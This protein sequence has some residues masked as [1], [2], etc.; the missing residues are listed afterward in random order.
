[1]SEVYWACYE[2]GGDGLA[3]LEGEERVSKP[4]EVR[5]P[6]QWPT[7]TAVGRGFIAYPDALRAAVPNVVAA[8][9]QIA[10]TLAA[11][12]SAAGAAS[13]VA[14]GAVPAAAPA[15]A[16]ADAAAVAPPADPTSI[17]LL[18]LLPHATQIAR[19]ALPEVTAGHLIP[20]EAA[21][22]IYLRDNVAHVA[23]PPKPPG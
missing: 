8:R 23:Q 1:M 14:A 20:A 4:S 18:Q 16:V 22:P 17:T 5:P 6:A 19:L 12:T 11:A 21:T 9:P 10:S 13:T 15:I 7:A 2:R 3:R